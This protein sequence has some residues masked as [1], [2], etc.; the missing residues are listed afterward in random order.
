MRITN[1]TT[2]NDSPIEVDYN[3]MDEYGGILLDTKSSM[4]SI[5]RLG[6]ELRE[7]E[8]VWITDGELEYVGVIVRRKDSLSV[9]TI[10]MTRSVL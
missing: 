5:G 4:D 1:I 8:L 6:L 2:V 3:H 10:N 7:G 9:V